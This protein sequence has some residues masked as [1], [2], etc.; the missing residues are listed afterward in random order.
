MTTP[1]EEWTLQ[2]QRLGQ[3]VLVFEQIDSTNNQARTLARPE[4]DGLVVL[5]RQQ[6]AGRGRQGHSWQAPPR[7]SVLLSVVLFPPADL[8]RP[9]LLTAWA[10]VAVA[11]LVR[12]HTGSMPRIKWPN[13]VLLKERKICGILLECVST[14]HRE[15]M[16]IAGIGL[17][18]TQSPAELNAA[19]L[20]QATSLVQ[21]QDRTP[22]PDRIAR[23]LIERLD[24]GYEQLRAGNWHCLESRWREYIG[25]LGKEVLVEHKIA[26]HPSWSASR[27]VLSRLS[28]EGVELERPG[29]PPWQVSAE[30][31]QQLSARHPPPSS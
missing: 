28:F 5:A 6:T 30:A 2:T 7:S 27:G 14:V 25:L 16:I 22:D 23:E 20:L 31:I 19:G 3:R 26:D 29:C 10:A 15:S 24:A 13:D 4:N 1:S 12:E 17:N 9:A 21:H 11:D 8:L 18:V